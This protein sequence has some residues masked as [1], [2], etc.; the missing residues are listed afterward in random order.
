MIKKNISIVVAA[1]LTLSTIGQQSISASTKAEREARFAQKI[2]AAIVQLGTGQSSQVN[3]KL[4]DNTKLTGYIS[5]I[6]DTSFVVTDLTSAETTTVSYP[7]VAQVKG[8]NLSTRTKIIIAA[9][10]IAGVA[11]TL[12][13]V[14]GAFCDGC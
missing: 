12:Y 9:A 8:N 13:I 10:V 4:R 3:L 1:L 2:K 11:I 7:N 14:R 6:G 5:E